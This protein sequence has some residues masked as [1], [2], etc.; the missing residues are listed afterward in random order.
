MARSRKRRRWP[1]VILFSAIALVGVFYVGGAW[2]FSGYV[3]DNGLKAEPYD[4]TG[5]QS[6]T[7]QAFDGTGEEATV[8]ILPDEADRDQRKFDDAVVGLAIG[9]SLLVAGPATRDAD[10]GQTRPVIDVIGSAPNVGDR[11]GLTRDVWLDPEQA[12]L[13]AQDVVITTPDGR[14]FP[15]WEIPVEGSTK[16][17]IL[18]HG[19]GASRSEMLRMARP[20]HKADYN[21]LIMNYTGDVG[22]PPYDDGVYHFGRTE[23]QEVQAAVEYADA[24]GAETIVLGGASHGGAVML[25]FLARGELARRVDGLILDAPASSFEDVIDEGAELISLPVGNLPIPESLEDAAKLAVAFRY[26]V[27][28]SAVDYTD[29]SGLIDVPVLT[30]QGVEDRTVPKAVNDRFMRQ[31][32]VGGTYEVVDGADHVL[33]WNVDPKAY[34]KAIKEFTKELDT[35]A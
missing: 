12:G 10:G 26:G 17:A 1:W 18:T 4:P 25:G 33:S 30:F 32:G 14:Q 7:V 3:Y 11:Y 5:L 19:T 28:Y 27:D 13:D 23:W 20:L 29:M 15:A 31:A 8:T 6:G 16:W 24:A 21:V 22:A 34:E 2:Y 35:A 9:E